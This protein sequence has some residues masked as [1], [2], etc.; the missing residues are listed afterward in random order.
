MKDKGV[1]IST[2]KGTA[3]VRVTCLSGCGD[4]AA[5]ALCIG[6]KD[7]SGTLSVRNPVGARQGDEVTISVPETSYTRSLIILF[8][9]LLA[10]V[11]A[12][13]GAGYAAGPL[14]SI[15]RSVSGTLGLTAAVL[16]AGFWLARYFRKANKNSLYPVITEITQKGAVH[17]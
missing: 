15:S 5:H 3:R 17:G 8:G 1:V 11:L 2:D 12:G 6:E 14:L 7:K 13:G 4:C 16:T 9:S 10:A